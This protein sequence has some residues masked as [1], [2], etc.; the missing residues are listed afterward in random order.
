MYWRMAKSLEKGIHEELMQKNGGL[1]RQLVEEQAKLGT[2][3][4]GGNTP[5]V[6]AFLTLSLL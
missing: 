6:S 5:C 2:N 3:W 1:Y 4:R